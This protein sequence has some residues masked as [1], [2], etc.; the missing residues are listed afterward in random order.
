MYVRRLVVLSYP[1]LEVVYEDY[2]M[3]KLK[4]PYIAGFLAF[5]EVDFLVDLL[6]KLWN[7][8]P[9]LIPQVWCCIAV[10][11]F[12]GLK[13]EMYTPAYQAQLNDTNLPIS[14]VSVLVFFFF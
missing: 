2:A 5:R 3:V 12:A 1:D 13:S 6:N 7:T 9:K 14:F 8:K 10:L 11:C 4:F